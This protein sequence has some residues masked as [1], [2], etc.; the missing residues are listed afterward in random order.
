M[1]KQLSLV[2]GL[3][4]FVFILSILQTI[5]L[6]IEPDTKHIILSVVVYLGLLLILIFYL[7][8]LFEVK[9]IIFETNNQYNIRLIE[10]DDYQLVR[11]LLDSSKLDNS[12][13]EAKKLEE[14]KKITV[15]FIRLHYHYIVFD[16]NDVI[17][18]FYAKKKKNTI[19]IEFKNSFENASLKEMLQEIAKN[20]NL[21]I[22][23]KD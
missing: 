2:K 4:I 19:S 12:P 7:I 13:E 23:F 9:K 5:M 20:N 11:Q 18:I 14:Y 1:K 8:C 21:E 16:K 17:G 3:L 10:E 15:D 6:I 22:I